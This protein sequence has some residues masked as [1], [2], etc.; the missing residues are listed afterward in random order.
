MI[1]AFSH[2]HQWVKPS[3]N[4]FLVKRVARCPGGL[5]TQ[6]PH[7]TPAVALGVV[8]AMRLK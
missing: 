3:A 5:Q 4:G 7:T 1:G 8:S 2:W 6:C